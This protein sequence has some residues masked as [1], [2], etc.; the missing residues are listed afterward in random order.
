MRWHCM[1]DPMRPRPPIA[2]THAQQNLPVLFKCFCNASKTTRMHEEPPWNCWPTAVL[3]RDAHLKIGEIL[4]SRQDIRGPAGQS[5]D[6]QRILA[7]L[8]KC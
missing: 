3:P 6:K 4:V 5:P 8:E 1:T 7:K 2:A